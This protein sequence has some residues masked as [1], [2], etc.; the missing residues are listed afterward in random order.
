VVVNIKKVILLASFTIFSTYPNMRDMSHF[1]NHDFM[2]ELLE[3]LFYNPDFATRYKNADNHITLENEL[4]KRLDGI[5][6]MIDGLNIKE[7]MVII[8]DILDKQVG[9]L[10]KK[11]GKRIGRYVY[12]GVGYGI[13][14]LVKFERDNPGNIQFVELLKKAKKDI[15]EQLQ[16]FVD[17]VGAT[18]WIVLPIME[19]WVEKRKRMHTFLLKWADC[20]GGDEIKVFDKNIHSLQELDSFCTDLRIFLGDLI[21]NCP[22]GYAQFKELLQQHENNK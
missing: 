6:F 21:H 3:Y 7:S 8:R 2:M 15:I 1:A 20:H 9:K 18:Q 4:L 11:T 22:K 12:N 17:Q 10:D 13:H 14:Q 16:P 19:E 5:P